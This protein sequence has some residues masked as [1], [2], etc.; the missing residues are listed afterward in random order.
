MNRPQLDLGEIIRSCY[1]AFLAKY[2]GSLT[3]AA[4][5]LG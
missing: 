3:R 4:A 2:G 1:D 5:G